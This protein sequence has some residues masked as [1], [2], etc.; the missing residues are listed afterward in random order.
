MQNDAVLMV[1]E[2]SGRWQSCARASCG[3]GRQL[4][5]LVQPADESARDFASRVSASVERIQTRD[6]QLRRV[7]LVPG[8]PEQSSR[9]TRQLLQTLQT[10]LRTPSV[11]L[12]QPTE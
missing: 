7:I 3:P 10:K 5:L 4:I 2:R 1:A 6:V 9:S 11:E 12:H 8:P